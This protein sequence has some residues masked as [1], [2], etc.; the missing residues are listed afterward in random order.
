M[1]PHRPN[2]QVSVCL[3]VLDSRWVISWGYPCVV[4]GS[5]GRMCSARKRI[6][7]AY[8]LCSERRSST[9]KA[10]HFRCVRGMQNARKQTLTAT[11]QLD[12][13]LHHGP[14]SSVTKGTRHTYQ[15]TIR[16]PEDTNTWSKRQWADFCFLDRRHKKN[17]CNKRTVF[18]SKSALCCCIFSFHGEGSRPPTRLLH[19]ICQPEM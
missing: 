17:K 3:F 1:L 6:A 11:Y 16:L 7:W 4:Y 8:C 14:C 10:F 2:Y 19:I 15:H 5:S 18:L 12:V 13:I 9:P